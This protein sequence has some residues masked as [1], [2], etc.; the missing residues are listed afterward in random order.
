[1]QVPEIVKYLK[2]YL[3][4]FMLLLEAAGIL[5]FIAYALDTTQFINVSRPKAIVRSGGTYMA[6]L[7]LGIILLVIVFIMCTV[8]YF[9]ERK[10]SRLLASFKNLVPQHSIVLRDGIEK[11]VLS[12]SCYYSQ[13]S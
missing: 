13:R 11:K 9:Q 2:Q 7:Y 1:M 8:A 10:S 6:Q 5:S 3:N 12:G 4:F